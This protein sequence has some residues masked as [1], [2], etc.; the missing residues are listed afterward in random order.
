MSEGEYISL[1]Y[2]E[3]DDLE[4]V[5]EYLRNCDTVSTIGLWGRS[6]GAIT[7]LMFADRDP[8]IGGMVLDSAMTDLKTLAEQL[9]KRHVNLPNFI[10]SGALSLVRKSV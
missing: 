8:S 1:G 7:S 2:Y 4:I 10:L 3:R 6:M 5:I 9:C